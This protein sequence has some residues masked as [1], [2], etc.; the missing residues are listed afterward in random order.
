MAQRY[1]LQIKKACIILQAFVKDFY[2][3]I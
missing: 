3:F 1:G 2:Y